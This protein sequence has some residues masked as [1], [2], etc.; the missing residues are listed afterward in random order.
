MN[1]KLYLIRH[2]QSTYNL[3]NRFTGWKDVDLTDLGVSQ[4]KEAAQILKGHAFDLAFT[5]NLLRAQ[6]TLS[7]ILN[8]L[9]MDLNIIKNEALNE[10]DYGDLVGQNK[11]EAALK[12]GEEQVQI[13]RRSFDT[14]PPN[15][16]S[17]KMTLDRTLPYFNSEIKP[18]LATGKNIILSAHGNSIRSIIMELFQYTSEQILETEVGWCE[19][20]IYTFNTEGEII[21]FELIPR[22]S[23]PSK[24]NFPKFEL[25][26]N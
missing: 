25:S 20:V 9:G 24:S 8:E 12:F 15:G 10:R 19:P 22:N 14:P 23:E 18:L 16:E 3:E 6:K 11:S 13:W 21:D 5:S 4:A 1:S 2:G 17:L 7:I 26:N